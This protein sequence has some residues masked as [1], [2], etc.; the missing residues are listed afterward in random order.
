LV[1]KTNEQHRTRLERVALEKRMV[2]E[3]ELR[4]LASP[5]VLNVVHL[6]AVSLVI[7]MGAD[8]G[9]GIA[10]RRLWT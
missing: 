3:E 5:D 2:A 10:E 8:G 1:A 4:Q 9:A 6:E 7:T